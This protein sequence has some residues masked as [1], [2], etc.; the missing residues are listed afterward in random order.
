MIPPDRVGPQTVGRQCQIIVTGLMMGVLM[1]AGIAIVST[2]DANWNKPKLLTNL[3]IVLVGTAL[4]ARAF[5]L[6]IITRNQIHQ[7]FLRESP[8]LDAALA[9]VYLNR[10]V[11]GGAFLEMAA[12]ANLIFFIVSHHWLNVIAAGSILVLLAITFPSQGKFEEWVDRVQRDR[13]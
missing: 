9:P 5:V 8:E 6:T 1:F 2:P 3:G 12:F 4:F 7:A 13:M 10:V 11:L